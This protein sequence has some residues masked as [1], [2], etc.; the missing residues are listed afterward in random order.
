MKEEWIGIKGQVLT[1]RIVEKSVM[2][3]MEHQLNLDDQHIYRLDGKIIDGLTSTIQEAG[4]IRNCD[5]WYGER[6]SALHLATEFY[7]RNT[8]DEATVDP[9]IQG[10]LSSWKRF[11]KDQ[12][13]TPVEIEYPTYH[14]E[15]LVGCKIDR[16]PGPVDLK[17]GSS[18][19]WHIL[20]IAFQTATLRIGHKLDLSSAPKD[21][22]LDPDGGPP[23]VKSYTSSELREAFKVYA[24]MLHFIR[25]RREKYGNLQRI[26]TTSP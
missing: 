2:L 24:S 10:Y 18:E 11:R 3:N 7:D 1:L 21:V 19:P 17:S 12:G 4:L 23:K 15:L 9:Q 6:G 14:P 26:E 16:L 8:L 13:Y 22:Y 5:P 20:Q 25:W